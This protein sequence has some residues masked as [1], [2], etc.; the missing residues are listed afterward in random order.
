[1]NL[2]HAYAIS[3][4]KAQGSEYPVV[5]LPIMREHQIMLKRKLI[6][7]AVSRAKQRLII[8]GDI[9]Q[10]EKG[11]QSI[12]KINRKSSLINFMDQE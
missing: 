9:E 3:V 5:I 6:Y 7:T 2:T 12:E 4:H 11:I 10:L 1:M 8:I